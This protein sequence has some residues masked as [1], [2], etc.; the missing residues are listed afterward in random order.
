MGTPPEGFSQAFPT[1]VCQLMVSALQFGLREARLSIALL[2]R[3]RLTLTDLTVG[4]VRT[5][6]MRSALAMLAD[7]NVLGI[8]KRTGGRIVLSRE[9][10][11]FVL[12]AAQ[13][14]EGGRSD[15]SYIRTWSGKKPLAE[16]WREGQQ[17]DLFLNAKPQEELPFV[18]LVKVGE[19]VQ[20]DD[21][22]YV[23]EEAYIGP[24][25]DVTDDNS[26][27]IERA[28]AVNLLENLSV[29]MPEPERVEPLSSLDLVDNEV[30]QSDGES[31]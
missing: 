11:P 20:G 28:T 2:D 18:L 12:Y 19:E 21:I 26:L 16:Q 5:D 15:E 30:K 31:E 9:G 14:M 1:G 4:N 6:A 24:I 17:T 27:L 25:A 13:E 29:S 8:H 23:V 22:F 7:D 10:L 3:K